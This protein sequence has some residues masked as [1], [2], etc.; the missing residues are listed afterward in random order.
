M[1]RV[2]STCQIDRKKKEKKRK[3][4]K[5]K[6]KKRESVKWNYL[7]RDFRA[8]KIEFEN[9]L[10]LSG[11]N[12]V[13]IV[14]NTQRN[15]FPLISPL[16]NSENEIVFCSL[17]FLLFFYWRVINERLLEILTIS[18]LESYN[19]ASNEFSNRFLSLSLFRQ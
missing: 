11:F 5:E 8:G 17:L 10:A 18:N 15:I 1:K 3:K 7:I 14:R 16:I 6:K 13:S 9:S 2:Y 19:R 12:W 4:K